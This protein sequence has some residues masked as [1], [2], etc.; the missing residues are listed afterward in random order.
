MYFEI[1]IGEN[2]MKNC[3]NWQK[4]FSKRYKKIQKSTKSVVLVKFYL[5]NCNQVATIKY[6]ISCAR[7][8][9]SVDVIVSDNNFV[10]SKRF[11]CGKKQSQFKGCEKMPLLEDAN[12]LYN[13]DELSNED[14]LRIDNAILQL[15]EEHGV[16]DFSMDFISYL[17][18]NEEFEIMDCALD[19]DTT[20]MLFVDLNTPLKLKN[21]TSNKL[22]VINEHLKIDEDYA[23]KRRFIAAHEYGHYILH[24]QGQHQY[25][26]R[27]TGHI[28]NHEELEAEYF[29]RSFLMPAPYVK[30]IYNAKKEKNSFYEIVNLVAAIFNV[31]TKKAR[32]RLQELGC[33]E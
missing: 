27:D 7:V 4:K 25:A 24:R 29:A 9:F 32:V 8:P 13:C 6:V 31:T 33:V 18:D 1:L 5:K 20:G 23:K 11:F 14:K 22:I 28:H 26:K 12:N 10:T 3:K 16:D 19:D 17:K 21:I 15:K 2:A 30:F